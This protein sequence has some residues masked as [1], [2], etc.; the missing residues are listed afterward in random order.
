MYNEQCPSPEEMGLKPEEV[1]A[2]QEVQ[3]EEFDVA[4]EQ[5]EISQTEVA[6]DATD[7]K[8]GEDWPMRRILEEETDK[9][10]PKIEMKAKKGLA[11]LYELLPRDEEFAGNQ[12][13]LKKLIAQ[14]KGLD[15]MLPA[16]RNALAR[17]I[18]HQKL[19][20]FNSKAEFIE[21]CMEIEELKIWMH[22]EALG[23]ATNQTL[24]RAMSE[25]QGKKA[26]ELP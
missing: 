26:V 14:T 5:A 19:Y 11:D 3:G 13:E 22:G 15:A 8:E 24:E 4:K 7:A 17:E 1:K 9:E 12:E 16:V 20:M 10:N 6:Q 18:S 21:K 2:L 25:K 23:A